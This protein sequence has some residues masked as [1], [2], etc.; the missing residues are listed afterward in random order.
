MTQGVDG[1][2]IPLGYPVGTAHSWSFGWSVS[3]IWKRVCLH[4]TSNPLIIHTL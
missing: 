4:V 1:A 2:I 3:T